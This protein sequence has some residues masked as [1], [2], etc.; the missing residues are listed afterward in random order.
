MKYLLLFLLSFSAMSKEYIVV[1]EK[2]KF[3]P[4]TVEIELGDV[5]NFVNKDKSLHNVVIKKLK[6]KSKMLKKGD[7]VSITP[8]K[9][10]D[11]DYYCQPHKAMGMKGLIKVK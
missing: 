10:G 7:W 11:F 9:K 2:M 4:S 8:N 3:K 1:M 5:V 6:F